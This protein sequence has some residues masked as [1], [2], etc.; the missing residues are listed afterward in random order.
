MNA[1]DLSA[2]L[3]EYNKDGFP[4]LIVDKAA[5]MLR[6]QFDTIADLKTTIKFLEEEC[7][8]LRS[9]VT[10]KVQAK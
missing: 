5:L 7:K 2:E 9:Q 6:Q 10:K 8:A 4:V 3:D 1:N